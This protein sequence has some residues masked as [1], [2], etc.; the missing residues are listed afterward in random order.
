MSAS[1]PHRR[2]ILVASAAVAAIGLMPGRLA[3]A[4]DSTIR[5]FKINVPEE[6]IAGL[7]R[8]LAATRWPDKETVTDQS[9]GV[10]LAKLQ[11]LVQYWS[12]GYDWRKVEA[13]LN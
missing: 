7:R 6:E 11:E 10:P 4:E 9:Q 1:L 12:N 8:R 2:D 13:R 3:A 5:P